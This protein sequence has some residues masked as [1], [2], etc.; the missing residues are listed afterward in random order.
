MSR[1]VLAMSETATSARHTAPEALEAAV[2]AVAAKKVEF[3]RLPVRD[4]IELLKALMRP[5]QDSAPG[6]VREACR[7]KGL[8]E[9][10]PVSGEEWLGGPVVT[11]R[12]VRL[13]IEALQQL[14]RAGAPELGRGV[15]TLPSGQLAIEAFPASKLDKLLFAGFS[16]EVRLQ[17]GWD[18]Q[19]ARAAQASFYK[20]KEPDGGLT[21]VLGAGN[22]SSIPPMDALYKMFVE[23]NVC[24]IKMNPVNEY[25]GPIFEQAL[26]PLIE[27][28]YLRIVYGGGDVGALLCQHEQVDDIHITGSDRTHDLIVWGPPG[29]ERDRR[30]AENQPLLDK[31]ITSELGNVS[32]V[33]VVPADYSSSQ[34][35]FQ[36]QS[37]ASQVTNNASFNC[38]A[39]KMLITA[40]GWK[41]RGEFLRLLREALAAVPLRKAYY[42]GAAG[43]YDTLTCG[44]H[45]IERI[46]APAEGEL[47]WTLITDLDPN[48]DEPQF[49]TEP[50]C[51][52]LSC[53][54]LPADDPAEF[55]AEATSF[56]NDR[57]WGTLSA[58]IIIHPK[59]EKDARVGPAFERA[60]AELRYG[61]LCVNHWPALGYGFVT[62]PW[63]GHP[64]ATLEDIQSGLGW[65]H[66]TYMLE[67]IEK[68]V[69]RGPLTIFPKP[70]WFNNHNRTH[71]VAAR[72]LA[73]E[74]EPSWSKLPSVVLSAI[75]G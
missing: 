70:P 42:P 68:C 18:R 32:P 54:E 28:D 31:T 22:V 5:I 19:R 73:L 72:M 47:P 58:C 48:R 51:A 36:A 21:L 8:P 35:A 59:Q 11:L 62:T 29:P 38:N 65:V 57:L 66:N 41:Q 43:R 26:A 24:V 44:G 27:R 30:R 12:N 39:A 25:L 50:F 14:A 63:G 71:D 60:L 64:S 55:L 34:L 6:W 9:A 3:A 74:A 10:A 2:A 69:V 52:V 7:A 23:G 53:V 61:T 20:Q 40:K 4:K 56:A 45:A 1:Q 37:V 49:G 16:A 46:G 17:P 75:R 15:R 33:I 67:G 13:L